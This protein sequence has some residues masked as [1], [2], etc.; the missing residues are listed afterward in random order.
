M[1]GCICKGCHLSGRHTN[2]TASIECSAQCIHMAHTCTIKFA[3][4]S[5]IIAWHVHAPAT[6]VY[7]D[8]MHL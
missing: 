5:I 1:D 3:M 4:Q 8:A 6:Y 7:T 2:F